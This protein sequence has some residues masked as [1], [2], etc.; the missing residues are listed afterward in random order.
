MIEYL[1]DAVRA[2]AGEDF[3][4]TAK[5]TDDDGNI[6]TDVCHVMIHEDDNVIYTAPGSLIEDIWYFTIPG[7]ITKGRKGRY[8]YC[9]CHH[10]TSM[11]FK[12]P[13]YLI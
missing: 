13:L 9:I 8:F 7:E 5:L 12:Q 2:T 11:C 6:I 1:Y 3:T 4:I 10:E